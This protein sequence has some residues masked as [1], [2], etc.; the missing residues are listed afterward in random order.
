MAQSIPS[1]AWSP[2][3]AVALRRVPLLVR[4]RWLVAALIVA[5]TAAGVLFV[6]VAEQD[7]ARQR[8]AL[9]AER[10]LVQDSLAAARNANALARVREADL[11]V[12]LAEQGRT[13]AS[14]SGFLK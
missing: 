14:T 2:P 5:A 7:L 9:I 8:D 11:R 6:E 10:I 4:P 1:P 3:S 12:R 13:L